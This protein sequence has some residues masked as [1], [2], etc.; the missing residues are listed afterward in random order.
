MLELWG[1]LLEA[2]ETALNEAAGGEDETYEMLDSEILPGY[3]KHGEK[4]PLMSINDVPYLIY[5]RN[6][7]LAGTPA[8]PGGRNAPH[9]GVLDE[10]YAL[11]DDGWRCRW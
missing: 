6:T 1:I 9:R 11:P 8:M 3:K 10:D 4:C 2:W 5:G 7:R